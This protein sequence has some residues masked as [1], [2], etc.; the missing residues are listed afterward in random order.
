MV[1]DLVNVEGCVEGLLARLQD[2][3]VFFDS[4]SIVDE[5]DDFLI[6]D[7][8]RSFDVVLSQAEG[9]K[10]NCMASKMSDNPVK[11][12]RIAISKRSIMELLSL[13]DD[14]FIYQAVV[15]SR[16]GLIVPGNGKSNGKGFKLV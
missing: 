16:S 5:D 15:Q 10:I 6:L 11:I 7:T 3:F 1:R 9:N 2:R 13:G 4:D 8:S 12:K 14:S